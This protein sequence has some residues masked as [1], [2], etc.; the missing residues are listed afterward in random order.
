MDREGMLH[1]YEEHP[2]GHEWSY[3]AKHIIQS[4]KFFAGYL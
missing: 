1:V 2:G 4:L 3:W